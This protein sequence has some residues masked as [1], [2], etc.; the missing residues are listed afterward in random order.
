[1]A[2][3]DGLGAFHVEGTGHCFKTQM[4]QVDWLTH[5]ELSTK[6]CNYV[7]TEHSQERTQLFSGLGFGTP[8]KQIV[9]ANRNAN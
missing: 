2:W 9:Y 4:R 3:S 7:R 1:M 6:P 8:Y 5:V